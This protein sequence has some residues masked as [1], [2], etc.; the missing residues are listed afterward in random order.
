[1]L[2]FEYLVI[3]CHATVYYSAYFRLKETLTK[4]RQ[5]RPKIQQQFSDLK[6]KLS[7]ITDDEWLSIP[8]VGDAR[9][10]KQRNPKADKITPVP[11]SIL[12]HAAAS[13]G[14]R[15]VVPDEKL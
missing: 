3:E 9:N 8:E 14:R 7:Q 1:M 15:R 11:D 6:R 5:E 12:A 13:T 10:K 4:F 2:I